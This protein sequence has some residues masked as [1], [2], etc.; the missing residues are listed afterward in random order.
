MANLRKNFIYNTILTLSGYIF[1]LLTFPYISRVLGVKN[2]GIVNFV[3]SVI[4]YFILFSTLGLAIVGLREIARCQD[5]IQRD[6]I[7]SQLVSIHFTLSV[8]VLFIYALC[9]FVIPQL[10]EYKMLFW[11]GSAKII[12][13]VFLVEWF[14]RGLQNFKYVTLRS[15]FTRTLYVIAIFIFVRERND[16]LLYFVITIGQ[17]L[18]NAAINWNYSRRYVSFVPTLKGT[19]K[20]IIPLFSWGTNMILLSFYSTFNV[21]YLGFV[22]G[23]IAVGYY[24]T[25]TKLYSIIL[26]VLQ[27]YNGVFIPYLNSLCSKGEIEE[28]KNTIKKSFNIVSTLSIPL[29]AV[30]FVLAPEIINIIAGNEFAPAVYPFRIVLFQVLIIGISQITNSQ[31]LL[32]LKKDREILISTLCGT[33]TSVAILLLFVK[34]Y[35][36]IAAAYAVTFSH[37]VEFAFLFYFAKKSL[38]FKFPIRS[39]VETTLYTIPMIVFVVFIKVVLTGTWSILLVSSAICTIY[40]VYVLYFIKKDELIRKFL[41]NIMLRHFNYPKDE[42]QC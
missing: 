15:I 34:N 39:F 14:F 9:I 1:P 11:I 28:F 16:Y 36:E 5:R 7:F 41:N 27:A 6:K 10:Y 13:N 30:C 26:S 31:I 38:D 29:V 19:K 37:L 17:V 4:D 23:A 32:S 20:F 42:E 22:S 12:L 2:V 3:S 25:A 24:T 35:G 33:T 8:I 18:L 21:M 40:Y